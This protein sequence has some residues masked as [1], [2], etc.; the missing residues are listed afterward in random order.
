MKKNIY[1]ITVCLFALQL[2]ARDLYVRIDGNDQNAGTADTPELAWQ[3]LDHAVSQ[4]QVGDHLHVGDGLY[5]TEELRIENLHG[6]PKQVTTISANN[7]W[8]AAITQ[9]T[10]PDQDL[11]V[12][13]VTNS[14]YVVIDGFEIFDTIDTGVGVD[15]RDGSHHVT[16]RHNYVHDCGCNGIAS[17]TS[18]Y[19]IF[20]G[21]VVRGNAKRNKWNCSGI[22]VW[23][24]IEHDQKSGYHIEIRNN[25]AF[26]NECDLAFSPHGHKNPTD[27]NGIIIDDFRN[28]QG[29]GQEGG[30]HAAVLVENNLAF[31]NG[32]RGIAVYKSDNVTIRNNTSF[33]N[34]YVLSNYMDFPGDISLDNST[35]SQIYNNL[36]VKNPE[37][38]TKA[39]RCYDNDSTNTRVFNNLVVGLVDF[40]GQSL[41]VKDNQLHPAEAQ[42]NAGLANPNKTSPAVTPAALRAWFGINR[43]SPAARSGYTG[44]IPAK[45]LGG[46][47]R[48]VQAGVAIGCFE[49]IIQPNP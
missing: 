19:L 18:D 6:S 48:T 22:T 32:G 23:H 1:L 4:L 36:I 11:A 49:A 8:Q 9:Q 2:T 37:L 40:C 47:P 27:G 33:H 21:N 45:D 25:V 20:E 5:I 38:P 7:R 39:L 34:L 26:E 24:P 10:T 43:D 15:V 14:S 29:G 46:Y 3:T 35:G 44:D 16:I 41:F 28:T 31:N 30:Y 17:R 12:I 42:K 13:N